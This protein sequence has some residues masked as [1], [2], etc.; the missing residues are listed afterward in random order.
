M[1]SMTE[2]EEITREE[3][4]CLGGNKNLLL[5]C[6]DKPESQ[7]YWKIVNDHGWIPVI[8]QLPEMQMSEYG[9]LQSDVIFVCTVCG[10][11]HLATYEQI[12]DYTPDWHSFD[13][14]RQSLSD[15]LYWRSAPGLPHYHPLTKKN[16]PIEIRVGI[17]K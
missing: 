3:F 15:V 13:S 12:G 9:W 7:T 5:Y 6:E 4:N 14:E 10:S 1:S 2:Y 11:R 16:K 8:A 17:L